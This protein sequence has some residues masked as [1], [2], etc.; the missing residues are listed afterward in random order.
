M[1]GPSRVR[2]V[3]VGAA[4]SVFAIA[5]ATGAV[6][7]VAAAPVL[8]ATR[9]P[10]VPAAPPQ[11]APRGLAHT[12]SHQVLRHCFVAAPGPGARAVRPRCVHPGR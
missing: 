3:L 8:A 2:R 9:A 12:G 4:A 1:I 10:A 11:A 5:G 6:A 7:G